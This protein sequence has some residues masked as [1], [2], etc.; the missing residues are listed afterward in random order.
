MLRG[1]QKV[2]VPAAVVALALSATLVA[3][4]P[5]PAGQV[6]VEVG[7]ELNCTVPRTPVQVDIA[8]W[9]GTGSSDMASHVPIPVND[10]AS[11]AFRAIA[12]QPD[13]AAAAR[14]AACCSGTP[15]GGLAPG[16]NVSLVPL[17]TPDNVSYQ[18]QQVVRPARVRVPRPASLWASAPA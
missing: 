18:E 14:V 5:R 8:V 15:G 11:A 4:W 13:A 16:C 2:A 10:G 6:I 1:I 12:N 3:L 17:V 7:P 9:N